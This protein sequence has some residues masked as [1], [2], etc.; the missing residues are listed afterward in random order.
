MALAGYMTMRMMLLS[1]F[2]ALSL[3]SCAP[4]QV[5]QSLHCIDVFSASEPL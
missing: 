3:L 5:V 2:S 4:T 1:V